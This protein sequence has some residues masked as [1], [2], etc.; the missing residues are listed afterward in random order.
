M[1]R[2]VGALRVE[3]DEQLKLAER[4]KEQRSHAYQAE[5]RLEQLSRALAGKKAE[6]GVSDLGRLLQKLEAEVAAMS[7]RAHEELPRAIA[8]RQ[9][10]DGCSR[11][12]RAAALY[13]GKL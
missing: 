8:Q 6:A 13:R 10:R 5:Q 3:Q 12:L 1:L 9:R 11:N 4:M 7:R 2:E